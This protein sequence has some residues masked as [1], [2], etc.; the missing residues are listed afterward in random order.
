MNVSSGPLYIQQKFISTNKMAFDVTQ[1]SLVPKH[2]KISD[3]EKEKILQQ[4][5]ITIKELPKILKTDPALHSLN[6]KTGDVI[7]V[8]RRSATA[9]ISL[10]YRVVIDG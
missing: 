8:E 3:T 7:K 9:D 6:V 2:S 1:H 5:G 10:Y 4:Y